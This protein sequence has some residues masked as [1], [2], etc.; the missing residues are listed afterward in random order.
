MGI[1][2]VTP[3][4]FSDGNQFL[5]AHAA[6]DHA[7]RLLDEGA[8][9]VDLGGES[10]RPNA[11]P[12]TPAEEQERI[13]PVM[14]AILK[15]RR[16]AI[17]SVDTYHAET[18]ERAIQDGAEAINDV[19]GLIWD[20]AMAR[21]LAKEQPGSILMHTRGA[22]RGWSAL[23]PLPHADIMPMIVSGLA[24]TLSLARSAGMQRSNMV[25]DP[26]FGFGK[27]GDE[28]FTLLAHFT[29]LHQFAL[30]FLVGV[31]RKRFLTAH[32]PQANELTRQQATTA[33]NTAAILSGAH[34]LRVHD[35]PAARTA[36]TVADSILSLAQPE[37]EET[38]PSGI[39]KTFS[40]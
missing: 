32:L 17:L 30:P 20:P 16:D 6:V 21:V 37:T 19:S 23:P 36:A 38:H 10:T 9:L 4:S 28:N 39:R 31:S 8:D 15:L 25:L 7:L 26:G 18:A 1:L 3:D 33:A 34:I 11:T 27:M 29:E 14:K 13:L 2:N 22:P 35:I 24:H 5:N 12:I 40:A